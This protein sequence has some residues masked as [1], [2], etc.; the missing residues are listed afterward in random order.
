M[1]EIDVLGRQCELQLPAFIPFDAWGN[2]VDKLETCNAWKRQHDI[3][4]EEGIVAI[5]YERKLNEWRYYCF[6][7]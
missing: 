7:C 3:S 2:R 6:I 4:A 5:G 1:D